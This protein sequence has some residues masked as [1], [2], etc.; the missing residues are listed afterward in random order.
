MKFR[1]RP[2]LWFFAFLGSRF[3]RV[4]SW[5]YRYRYVGVKH[6]RNELLSGGVI[7]GFWHNRIV[8]MT[9]T[10]IFRKIKTCVIV[11]RHFDGELIVRIGRYFGHDFVRG[12][13]GKGGGFGLRGLEEK[14]AAG[15]VV[16]ITPDGAKGPVY[17]L[18]P[19]IVHLARV[20]GRPILPTTVK[21]SRKWFFST[22]DHFQLPKP[23]STITIIFGDPLRHDG[24]DETMLRTVE[25]AMR[26]Q[27]DQAPREEGLSSAGISANS[28]E[29]VI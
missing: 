14:V 13:A 28:A 23:F 16:G 19:G 20:T 22:W 25:N 5:T 8:G 1:S 2:A 7:L 17:V 15:Y 11:S 24:D 27:V 26:A 3:L 18:K 9:V 12:S 29:V 4:L 10:P 21:V 6:L